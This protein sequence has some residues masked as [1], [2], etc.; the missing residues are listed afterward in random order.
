MF[1]LYWTF[2]SEEKLHT[3][4]GPGGSG[5]MGG[6]SISCL[7]ESNDIVIAGFGGMEC[8]GILWDL[9]TGMFFIE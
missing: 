2:F 8:F 6:G 1:Y 4:Q 5:G 3:F 7:I 9:K